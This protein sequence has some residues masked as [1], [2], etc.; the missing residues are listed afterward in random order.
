MSKPAFVGF[1]LLALCLPVSVGAVG[2]SSIDPNVRGPKAT[3]AAPSSD[4]TQKITYEARR[5]TVL[6]ILADLHRISGVTLK[7]GYSNDDWQVRDRRMNIFAKDVPLSSLMDSIAR[8][9]NFQ[10]S[11]REDEGVVSYRLYMDRNVLLGA[12]RQRYIE[13]DSLNQHRTEAL[14]KLLSELDKAAGMSDAELENLKTQ[15]PFIY[16]EAKQGHAKFLPALCT[17]VPL[18]KQALLSGEALT[19][20]VG[21]LPPGVQ[22][23]VVGL[24]KSLLSRTL[25]PS[26]AERSTAELSRASIVLN[27]NLIQPPRG[28]D[29]TIIGRLEIKLPG[30]MVCGDTVLDPDSGYAKT[31]GEG[32]VRLEDASTPE[33]KHVIVVE[34]SNKV[35]EAMAADAKDLGEPV[36]EHPDDAALSAKMK[37]KV[38]GRDFA[39]NLSVLAKASSFAVV[40]DSFDK[41]LWYLPLPQGETTVR[42]VLNGLESQCRYNWERHG[43]TLELRDRDWFRKRASQIPEAW[44]AGWRKTLQGSGSLDIDELSRI[45]ALSHEQFRTNIRGDEVFARSSLTS[46]VLNNRDVLCFYAS[47]DQQQRASIF[48]AQGLSIDS[49]ASAKSSAAQVFLRRCSSLKEAA[50]GGLSLL[51]TRK[52]QGKQISYAFD[53]VTPSGGAT[54]AQWK[55]ECP[56]Y[57][58]PKEEKPKE[59]MPQPADKGSK[60]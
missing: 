10:W 38:E 46:A 6:S 22:Q 53:V 30:G 34:C 11:K 2:K 44:V 16:M 19:L 20:S 40:S 47:L 50:E 24:L 58:P 1:L 23:G 49:L 39:D 15:S 28:M 13:E 18:A 12:E 8:V 9:M 27:T 3:E 4:V 17:Q 32:F 21:S 29:T 37:M 52:K 43:V 7:A 48:T 54:S 25:G 51:G 5:Q 59:G 57:D 56:T 33:E 41:A 55:L 14:E 42:A 36:T 26:A 31:N 35:M 60:Q 45:A